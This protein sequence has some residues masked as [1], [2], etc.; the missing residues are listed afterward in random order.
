MLTPSSSQQLP[1]A[2][3]MLL[4]TSVN[5]KLNSKRWEKRKVEKVNENIKSMWRYF[6]YLIAA[7]SYKTICSHCHLM[8][9]AN[10]HMFY[11]EEGKSIEK[12]HLDDDHSL[13][14]VMD[15]RSIIYCFNDHFL[16]TVCLLDLF[17]QKVYG[18]SKFSFQSNKSFIA[19]VRYIIHDISREGQK[20][21]SYEIILQV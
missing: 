2:D 1:Q 10:P 3:Y 9:F 6:I 20:Q 8:S 5:E 17:S 7:F 19:H 21:H 11:E 13:A 14:K 15:L 12:R 4:A 16:P 18:N